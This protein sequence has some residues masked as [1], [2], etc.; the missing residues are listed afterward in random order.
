MPVDLTRLEGDFADANEEKAGNFDPIPDG[1]YTVEVTDAEVTTSKSGQA[2][3]KWTMRVV[4]G[5]YDN[6]LVW[7]N[8]LLETRQNL[9]W[10]KKDLKLCGIELAKLNDLNERAA[11]LCGLCLQITQK[12]TD[13]Y[14]N[15]YLNRLLTQE[16]VDKLPPAKDPP[17]N[18]GNGTPGVKSFKPAANEPDDTIP[19]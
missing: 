8:N 3:L 10:L 17:S 9:G 7:R 4:G 12:S 11:E 13:K 16:E 15:V 2:M 14:S 5:K 19:F 6:R 18:G 1:K